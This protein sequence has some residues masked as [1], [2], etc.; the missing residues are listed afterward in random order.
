MHESNFDI[1]QE[2]LHDILSF[3]SYFCM[4]NYHFHASL[5]TCTLCT[6]ICQFSPAIGQ[7]W[8]KFDMW[9]AFLTRV[10]PYE[11]KKNK[12]LLLPIKTCTLGTQSCHISSAA[13]PIYMKFGLWLV[14][15]II[16]VPCIHM[17][18]D[19]CTPS[20][21]NLHSG[22]SKLSY[23][24]RQW[25]DLYEIWFVASSHDYIGTLYS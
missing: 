7:I 6:Q 24:S 22:Y 23:L 1:S 10:G 3:F 9:L 20:Y 8:M 16:L 11:A 13:C 19:I 15:M 2:N 25:S 18:P 14:L 5:K 17:K 12:L 4:E 21:Q